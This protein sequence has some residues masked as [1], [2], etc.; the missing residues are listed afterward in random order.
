MKNAEYTTIDSHCVK[1]SACA[2]GRDDKRATSNWGQQ[3]HVTMN[4]LDTG[5]PSPHTHTHRASPLVC[6]ACVW[7]R[8][9]CSGLAN[10]RP[11]AGTAGP[12]V[13]AGLSAECTPRLHTRARSDP[14]LPHPNRSE[15]ALP[16]ARPVIEG[17]L[18]AKV[19]EVL[20]LLLGHRAEQ[21]AAP[22]VPA[23]AHSGNVKLAADNTPGFPPGS[24]RTWAP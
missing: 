4:K 20:L 13:S 3:R 16:A 5:S 19:A 14:R 22:A 9:R 23:F 7:R 10:L 8:L 12:G 2:G 6:S 15:P 11:R 1:D 18:L 24:C 21:L 17:M